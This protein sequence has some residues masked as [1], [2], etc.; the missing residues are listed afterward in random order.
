MKKILIIIA[1]AITALVQGQTNTTTING[2]WNTS[3][4]VIRP[5]DWLGTKNNED[6]I[7][8][9]NNTQKMVL[10]KNGNL[11][12]GTTFPLERLDVGGNLKF[13]GAL[14]PN[15]TAGATGQALISAGAGVP[16]TW[17]SVQ[18]PISVTAPITLTGATVGITTATTT[19][20][21]ALTG[22]DFTTFNNKLATANNGLTATGTLVEL[23]GT[24]TKNTNIN[25]NGFNL[26]TTGSGNVGIGTSAPAEKLDVIGQIKGERILAFGSGGNSTNFAGGHASLFNNTTGI[27]NTATGRTSLYNNTT[28][29]YNTAYGNEALSSNTIGNQNTAVGMTAL[30]SLVNQDNNTAV[31]FVA[32]YNILGKANTIIGANNRGT[33]TMNNHVIIG[34]GDGNQRIFIN[35]LGNMGLGTITPTAKLEVAGQVKITGGAPALGKVLT[36]DATGLATWQPVTVPTFDATINFSVNANPNTA[37]TTFNP[38]T[39]NSTTVIY[40]STIDGSQWTYNGTAYITA[41]AS[42]DWKVT[43]NAGTN[44]LTQFVGTTDNVGLPF[45]TNNIIR[46]F[47]TN[48]GNVGIGTTTPL[49]KLDVNGGVWFGVQKGTSD[50]GFSVDGNILNATAPTKITTTSITTP[51]TALRLFS[52]GTAAVKFNPSADFQIGTYATGINA[53]TKLNIKLGNNG[54]QTPDVDVMTLQGNGNV[55]IGT[56]APVSKLDVKGN[57]RFSTDN[58]LNETNPLLIVTGNANTDKRIYVQTGAIEIQS[59]ETTLT[60]PIFRVNRAG[61]D[62]ITA[63]ANGNVGIGT[64]APNAQ[65][66]LG[67]TVANRKIVLYEAANNDNQ[68]YGL[69]INAG[70]LRYQIPA[71]D[72]KHIFY[73]GTSATASNALMTI[74]GNGNVGIG[75]DAPTAKLHVIGSTK[76]EWS[77]SNS[78]F[79]EFQRTGQTTRDAYIGYGGD[80]NGGIDINSEIATKPIKLTTANGNVLVSTG[81]GNVGIGTTAPTQKL[82]VIGNIIASGTITPSDKRLKSNIKDVSYGVK[83][84]LKLKAVSYTKKFSLDKAEKG[85]VKEIGFIAQDLQ[86]ILPELVT[87]NGDDKL[88]AV[89][90][91]SLIPILIKAIQE[92]QIEIEKLKLKIK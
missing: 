54:T 53:L 17:G 92:Q 57:A 80:G 72:N 69:G 16:P 56:T 81:T 70:V 73:A 82:H 18:A 21:G 37:G 8:K 13:S 12:I 41:P 42:A 25:Q 9:T 32:G 31:G 44:P 89:N 6:L 59:N 55:G 27:F 75:T 90:Y 51:E 43:G 77:A 14:M 15:N 48:T 79:I 84:L 45:R 67:N 66:Q 38:N 40:V 65:L 3:G 63:L 28:G 33:S 78:G 7:F 88:L 22:A 91:T 52:A 83:E 20:T 60:N 68:Y 71:A 76:L 34:D 46:Q 35:D 36:S 61:V 2:A 85:E 5:F 29:N 30:T 64:T 1:I 62:R 49:S 4:N 19:T 58:A 23:G 26:T 10:T 47:I 11:G 86:K 24:L 50:A 87:E 74:Q 39:P